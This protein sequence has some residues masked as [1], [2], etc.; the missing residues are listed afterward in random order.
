[1]GNSDSHTDQRVARLEEQTTSLRAELTSVR[2]EMADIRQI[3]R[4]DMTELKNDV[5]KQNETLQR[6]ELTMERLASV[7]KC[8]DPGACTT[9]KKIQDQQSEA[10]EKLKDEYNAHRGERRMIT[11]VWVIVSALVAVAGWLIAYFT[12]KGP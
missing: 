5:K 8:P 10:I 3:Q 1:M 9:V 11:V 2:Q 7:P 4:A 6:I 12:H